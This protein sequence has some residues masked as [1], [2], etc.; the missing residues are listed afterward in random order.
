MAH[1]MAKTCQKFQISTQTQ[2]EK[3]VSPGMAPSSGMTQGDDFGL[4]GPTEQ[5]ADFEKKQ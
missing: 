5:V 4:R 2:L 3:S 1:E